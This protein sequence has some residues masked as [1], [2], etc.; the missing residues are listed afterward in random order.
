V[1]PQ[2]PFPDVQVAAPTPREATLRTHLAAFGIGV[3]PRLE[4]R[5]PSIDAALGDVVLTLSRGRPPASVIYVASPMPDEERW[6]ELWSR[7]RL[8][9]R[10]RTR[11]AWVHAP[12]LA[13]LDTPTHLQAQVART[14]ARL[15][16]DSE[17]RS[18]E[19]RLRH[20]GIRAIAC[21]GAE[22]ERL[23]EL[24]KSPL[25]KVSVAG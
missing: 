3:P 13:A 17:R 18:A 1:L 12:E 14:A 2:A 19:Q 15:R 4:A 21:A 7:L 6:K 25:R 16:A 20:A 22:P 24:A 8:V 9:P 5:S 10:H 11:L 23:G